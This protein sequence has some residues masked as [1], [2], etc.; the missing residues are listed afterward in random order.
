MMVK[1][2]R[3]IEYSALFLAGFSVVFIFLSVFLSLL[4]AALSTIVAS[5]GMILYV[6]NSNRLCFSKIMLYSL[7]MASAPLLLVFFGAIK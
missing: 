7:F 3:W 5:I 2:Y 1:I 4:F 6:L